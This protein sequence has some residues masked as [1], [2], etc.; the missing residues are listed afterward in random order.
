MRM[1]WRRCRRERVEVQIPEES[2]A[3]TSLSE[4][5][6][7]RASSEA[8]LTQARRQ[9]GPIRAVTESLRDHGNANHFAE[10]LGEAFRERN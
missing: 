4:A 9:W 7:A 8:S 3:P 5:R 1:P 6:A 2:P 10:R